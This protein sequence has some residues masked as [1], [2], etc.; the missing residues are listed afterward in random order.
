M[1]ATASESDTWAAKADAMLCPPTRPPV[2]KAAA[3]GA[4]LL[5]VGLGGFVAWAALAP[6]SSAAVAPG[7]V[8]VDS[9]RKTLQH[10]QGG[11]IADLLVREGQQVA[12]GEVLMRLDDVEARSLHTVL[13][14]QYVALMAQ[15][16]RLKADLAE[17]SAIAFPQELVTA[18]ALHPEVAEVLASQERIFAVA[19]DATEGQ[20]SVLQQRI[21]QLDAQMAAMR[22][23]HDA[24]DTQARLLEEERGTVQGLVKAGLAPKPRLLTLQRSHADI[25]GRR[26]ELAN[27]LAQ[28]DEAITQARMEILSVRRQKVAAA[29]VELRDVET[30]RAEVAER[31]AAS[32]VALGRRQVVAPLSGTVLNLQYHTVGGVVGPGQPIMDIVPTDD[33]LVVRAKIRPLDIDTVHPGLRAQIVL[34]AYSSR[35]LPQLDGEV[36]RVSADALRDPN[37]GEEFFEA[38]LRV[39]GA[40]LAALE[41]VKLVPGM[42]VEA[43]IET[44]QRTALDYFLEP[45]L[46]SFRRAMRED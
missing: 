31:R 17:S 5:T 29:A 7:I 13:D 10:E 28:A 22:A 43:F 12:A 18:A 39:E 14:G 3:F 30:R 42:P 11:I 6:L 44:S 33:D 9:N 19:R 25:E 15:E 2:G 38:A 8:V 46:R 26:G 45:V 24:L 16:A 1:I 36:V 35:T 20:V 41:N 23:Q 32:A 4:L 34:S 37:T 21:A 40:Q 27:R